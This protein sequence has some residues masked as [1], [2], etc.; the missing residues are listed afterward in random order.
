MPTKPVLT[1]FVFATDVNYTTGPA[2]LIGTSTKIAMPVAERDEGW[3]ANQVPPAQW[4]NHN[5]N[6]VTQWTNWVALGGAVPGE[7]ASVLECDANGLL[8][9]TQ[10][11]AGG[12]STSVLTMTLTPPAGGSGS[13]LDVTPPAAGVGIL[14]SG[15]TSLA[16]ARCINTGAGEALEAL[17]LGTGIALDVSGSSTAAV[18]AVRVD[19]GTDAIGVDVDGNGGTVTL[20]LR[21]T[22]DDGAP[23]QFIKTNAGLHP[24]VFIS[25]HAAPARAN[26]A[27]SN[28]ADPSIA[29]AGDVWIGHGTDSFG[30]GLLKYRVNDGVDG[31]GAVGVQTVWSTTNGHGYKDA[32]SLGVS[33]ESAGTFATKVTLA[34]DTGETTPGKP[35]GV[36]LIGFA[37]EVFLAAGGA[38]TDNI[39]VKLVGSA[40][41]PSG[42]LLLE[43]AKFDALGQRATFTGVIPVVIGASTLAT[44]TLEWRTLNNP[45]TAS[46]ENARLWA[47]G[48]MNQLD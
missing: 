23:A 24:T 10:M 16:S 30:R 14:A 36:W 27:L 47:L 44:F 4:S 17:A 3:K 33:N 22:C 37:C 8:T 28:Q 46:I 25:G 29:L 43:L 32:E 15:S 9:L 7:A 1:P 34:I 2:L 26:L 48:A 13:T 41:T 12:H 42:T 5:F 21:V 20:G 31:G 35:A 18:P 38:V 40:G 39:E 19:T 45:N 11:I 6:H